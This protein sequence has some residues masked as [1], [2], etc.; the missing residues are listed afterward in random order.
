[1]AHSQHS[2][3]VVVGLTVGALVL[4]LI[5]AANIPQ[6]MSSKG[7]NCNSWEV[8]KNNCH[9][10]DEWWEPAFEECS[11]CTEICATDI[12]FCRR[13]CPVYAANKFDQISDPD[14]ACSCGNIN[15]T[16]GLIAF[17]GF[18]FAALL[19][20]P[21]AYLVI[22]HRKRSHNHGVQETGD[23][24]PQQHEQ[25][26]KQQQQLPQQQQHLLSNEDHADNNNVKSLLQ[27]TNDE[28]IFSSAIPD[29]STM[30][31]TPSCCHDETTLKVPSS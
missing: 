27:D 12:E 16:C 7:Y 17:I 8:V 19:A 25:E 31:T 3:E 28:T 2:S 1:M 26:L 23:H 10:S 22:K 6:N 18:A 21:L 13:Y 5:A 15:S 20:I 4:N 30:A 14:T 24:Q 9:C 29:E 11:L